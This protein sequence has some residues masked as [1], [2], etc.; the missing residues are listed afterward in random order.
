MIELIYNDI[1]I[2]LIYKLKAGSEHGGTFCRFT[3]DSYQTIENRHLNAMI[4]GMIPVV[5]SY[6]NFYSENKA[7]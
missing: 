2:S 7:K 6:A 3:S 4:P 1:I 5:L